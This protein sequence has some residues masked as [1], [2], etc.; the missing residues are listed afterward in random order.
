MS[1]VLPSAT[2]SGRDN[3][4]DGGG[5][6]DAGAGHPF[7]CSGI[8]SMDPRQFFFGGVAGQELISVS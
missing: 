6:R 1:G 2:D 3:V 5:V 8:G 7:G 4:P